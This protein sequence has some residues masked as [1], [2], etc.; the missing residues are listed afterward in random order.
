MATTQKAR[1]EPI[2]EKL[3]PNE[4]L[5]ISRDTKGILVACNEDGKVTLKRVTPQKEK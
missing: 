3:G 1:T 2:Y 4:C 5:I